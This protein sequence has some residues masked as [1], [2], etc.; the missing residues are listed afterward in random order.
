VTVAALRTR[1]SPNFGPRLPGVA[2]DTLVLH[3]TGMNS[4]REALDRLCDPA[5]EVSAHYLVEEDG[6]VWRLVDEERRAWHAGISVWKGESNLNDRS[7]G[8]E[9]V[10]PGHEFGYRPFPAPQMAAV[11][12]L[13]RDNL[14]RRPIPAARVLGH[15]DIA[16][17]RKRDP[18]ELFDWAGLA[19]QGIGV[20]PAAPG[21]IPVSDPGADEDSAVAGAVAALAAIGYD[22]E[23]RSAGRAV[24]PD[25]ALLAAITA[26]QRRFRPSR[27]DG[28][29]DAETC[30]LIAAVARLCG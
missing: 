18:G 13:C 10:N 14:D 16:P 5:A 4:A 8:V 22:I 3:Y 11:A 21:P 29:P 7:I 19:A 30:A 12:A 6:A 1:R 26:F 17:M 20:W 9:I 24:D 23:G 27:V 25:A 28:A 2:I 15:S